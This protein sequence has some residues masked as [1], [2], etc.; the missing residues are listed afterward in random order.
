MQDSLKN[1][2]TTT[3]QPKFNK[4]DF[5]EILLPIPPNSEQN[6]IAAILTSI[7]D[8]IDSYQTKLTSLTK[9][10]SA[11][12]QQLLTGKTRVKI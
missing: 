10:K 7:D 5:K 3:A 9:L 8:Q 4:T 11:L 6:H 1:I 12:M 2:T